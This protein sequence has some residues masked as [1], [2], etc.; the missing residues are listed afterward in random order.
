MT[1][2]F[3]EREF[4]I[5]TISNE[6]YDRREAERKAIDDKFEIDEIRRKWNCPLRQVSCKPIAS[7]EWGE[8]LEVL[9]SKLGTGMIVA[10][11][12]GRGNGKTQLGVEIMKIVSASL[13][14]C[15]FFTA[16]EFFMLIKST[17]KNDATRNEAQ[18]LSD[19][20]KFKLLV[21]DEIGKRSESQ[22]ENNL[23]FELINKRYGDMTDTLIIDNRQKTDF[24]ATIGP[25]LASRISETGGIIECGWASF[26]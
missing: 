18:I 13:E 9:K 25:S 15:Y 19:L 7:G 12:G 14:K 23:L 2:E 5:K 1:E 16:T 3:Q 26:R 17:Y 6:E 8:K 21:I 10:L 20:R 22:W 24:I 4:K 11:T